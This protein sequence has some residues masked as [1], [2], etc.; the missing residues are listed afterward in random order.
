MIFLFKQ[1]S[2]RFQPLVFE[3]VTFF[4]GELKNANVLC[5]SRQ[6]S[7]GHKAWQSCVATKPGTCAKINGSIMF[8]RKWRFFLLH[9]TQVIHRWD[10]SL[11][12]QFALTAFAESLPSIF[13]IWS[14]GHAGGLRVS[15][16]FRSQLHCDLVETVR[17]SIQSIMQDLV[18]NCTLRFQSS[19]GQECPR[20][21]L[22]VMLKA[23]G[24]LHRHR[25]CGGCHRI[26][27]AR[28]KLH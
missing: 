7:C 21:P 10:Q 22:K 23:F 9:F 20:H 17:C 28:H 25:Q 14:Y 4:L 27:I 24:I 13:W 1:A 18:L 11:R 2:F 26:A 19:N 12:T 8:P 6:R 15:E 3:G 5:R 16:S